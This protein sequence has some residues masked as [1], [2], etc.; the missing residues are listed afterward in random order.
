MDNERDLAH[1]A[2]MRALMRQQLRDNISPEE[3]AEELAE[4]DHRAELEDRAAWREGADLDDGE[5]LMGDPDE[6]DMDVCPRCHD[7]G[8]DPDCDYLLPCPECQGEQSAALRPYQG[9]EADA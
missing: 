2:D 4:R 6:Y 9:G 3:A 7:D 1:E 8:M 5:E